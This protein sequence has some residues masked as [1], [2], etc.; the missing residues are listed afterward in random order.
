MGA[1]VA[2]SILAAVPAVINPAVYLQFV[3]MYRNPGQA[4][5][6]ELPAPS[7]GSFLNLA[8]P[9]KSL[10]I[11]FLPPIAGVLWFVWHWRHHRDRWNWPEQMPL[12][13]LVSVST[14]AYAWTYDY[15]ILLPAVV[16][17]L[18]SITR[19]GAVWYKTRAALSYGLINGLYL[20]LKFVLVSDYYYF[21]L[22]PAFLLT[23]LTVRPPAKT[24]SSSLPE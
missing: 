4:T 22:A 24:A 15:V 13:L 23:Y 12:I 8:V 18:V 14:S 9:Q 7:L 1:I 11:Q 19:K 2:I 21:W 20:I 16:Q 5:P 17:A 10:L 6:F 3:E